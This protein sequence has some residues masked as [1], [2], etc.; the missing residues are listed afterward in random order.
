MARLGYERYGAQG[1]DM[2]AVIAPDV[3]RAAPARVVGVHVNAATFG[4]IPLGPVDPDVA[5]GLSDADRS[6]LEALATFTTEEWGY[7]LLQS[8]RPATLAHALV[9][10]PVGQ[11]AWIV[12]KFHAW[13]AAGTVRPDD[14]V[15]RDRMLTNV[16]LYWLTGTAGSSANM[17]YEGSHTGHFTPLV[18]SGVPTGVVDFGRDVAIRH[19]A[20][21]ANTIVHWTEHD[22]G[23]HFA[24]METPDLLVDDIRTFFRDI[25]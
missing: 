10:S 14:A 12:E 21:Q 15:D 23:G 7:H 6:R 1:G 8:T 25:R 16:M 5:A 22:V 20:E 19:F 2:G 18:N 11:L 4:F 13:T 17:Y 3:G 24:A 9:D